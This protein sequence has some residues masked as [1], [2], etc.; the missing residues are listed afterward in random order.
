MRLHFGKPGQ[1][2]G[3]G[4]QCAPTGT[5]LPPCLRGAGIGQACPD[6]P[7]QS[8]VSTPSARARTPGEFQWEAAHPAGKDAGA[9]LLVSGAPLFTTVERVRVPMV[10]GG[11]LGDLDGP[12]GQENGGYL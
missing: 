2:V 3:A 8:L 7:Q 11:D 12:G 4:A 1:H 5:Q 6:L 9:K 10:L